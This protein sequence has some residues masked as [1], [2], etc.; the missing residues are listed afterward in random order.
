MDNFDM[1]EL[2][3]IIGIRQTQVIWG[4]WGHEYP[5]NDDNLTADTEYLRRK[6][7]WEEWEAEK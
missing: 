2:F 1:K 3:D 5:E 7:C 4:V 6:K